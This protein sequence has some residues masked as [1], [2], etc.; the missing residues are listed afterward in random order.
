M[1]FQWN[2]NKKIYQTNQELVNEKEENT[3]NEE[4]KQNVPKG[5]NMENLLEPNPTSEVKNLVV[6]QHL[7]V[8]SMDDQKSSKQEIDDKFLDKDKI[9]GRVV[10]ELIRRSSSGPANDEAKNKILPLIYKVAMR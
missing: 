3:F 10:K 2:W 8:I 5:E 1:G 6:Q 7:R 9:A 4:N